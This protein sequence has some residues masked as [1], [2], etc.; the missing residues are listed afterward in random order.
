MKLS[1]LLEGI[2]DSAL[3]HN[4]IPT[5]VTR[6]IGWGVLKDGLSVGGQELRIG[7]TL[8]EHGWGRTDLPGGNEH[9]LFAS[10]RRL[11]PLAQQYP[12]HPGHAA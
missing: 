1:S 3:P 2:L 6:R 5:I 11:M 10:L 12:V 7:D 9:D 4:D 8:F